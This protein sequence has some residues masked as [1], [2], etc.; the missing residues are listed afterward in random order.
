MFHEDVRLKGLIPAAAAVI[1]FLLTEDM[2]LKMQLMDRW[3]LVM[4][5]ILLVEAAVVLFSRKDDEEEEAEEELQAEP[6]C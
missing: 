1:V 4:I 2:R 5:L 6:A 3:T